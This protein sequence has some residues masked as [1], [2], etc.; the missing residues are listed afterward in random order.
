MIVPTATATSKE[1]HPNL[2]MALPG[3]AAKPI[4]LA[5]NDDIAGSNRP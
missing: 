1:F 4:K 5:H 2:F 3:R